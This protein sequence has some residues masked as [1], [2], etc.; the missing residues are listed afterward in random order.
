MARSKSSQSTTNTVSDT[1]SGNEN[2]KWTLEDEKAFVGFLTDHV[3]ERGDG[4]YKKSTFN[5][6]AT[7]LDTMRTVGGPKT[8]QVCKNKW[9]RVRV[10]PPFLNSTANGFLGR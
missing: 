7:Y 9:A 10:Q 5:A 6:A 3:A 8:G 1:R 4:N 2:A